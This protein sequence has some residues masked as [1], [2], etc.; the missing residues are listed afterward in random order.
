MLLALAGF[1]ACDD[2]VHQRRVV[3][4]RKARSQRLKFTRQ[5]R[6]R[7]ANIAKAGNVS[8]LRA[9]IGDAG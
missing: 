6:L 7:A 3:V 5:R 4:G 2:I 1:L 8:L 9:G